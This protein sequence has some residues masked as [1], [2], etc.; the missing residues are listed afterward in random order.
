MTDEEDIEDEEIVRDH[1]DEKNS[2]DKMFYDVCK[3]ENEVEKKE[4][5]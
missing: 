5:K 4:S 1:K 2:D 3:T